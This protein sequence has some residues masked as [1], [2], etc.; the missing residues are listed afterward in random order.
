MPRLYSEGLIDPD[1][2]TNDR[3]KMDAKFTSDITGFGFGFQ[4]ST[5]YPSMNDGKRKVAGI[6]YL[7]SADGSSYCYNN[8]YTQPV[9][10]N[11]SLAVS[12]SN[13]N[14]AGTLKWLDQ[15]FGGEGVMYANYG[16]E[17][18]TY[19]MVNGEPT[20]TEYVTN[21]PDGKTLAQMVGLTC[22]VRDSAFP[23]LQTWQ[24]YKQTL[25]PWG[26]EAIE[27]WMADN[28]DTGNILPQISR[29]Q[30]ESER[31]SELMNP[32][33][34]YMQEQANKLITGSI[35]P[36]S[37]TA[38]WQRLRRW[39]LMRWCRFRTPRMRDIRRDNRTCIR[40]GT[41]GPDTRE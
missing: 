28:A 4:P 8:A 32:I 16:K 15:L 23:M 20:F 2:L 5:Y 41:A 6:G 24:Y 19:E 33:K 37:G 21:N 18:E 30:E 14:V 34:T 38:L 26:I 29:T 12:A 11:V 25:Q 1:Y 39:V 3:P 17:G 40:A 7:K 35:R 13:P 22:A 36:E 31:Y 9:M 10:K 27:T